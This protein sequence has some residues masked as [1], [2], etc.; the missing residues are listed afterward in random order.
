MMDETI[1]DE[2][3]YEIPETRGKQGERPYAF[4]RPSSGGGSAAYPCKNYGQSRFHAVYY[5]GDFDPNDMRRD[6]TCTV[7]GSTGDG[8]EK[9][10]PFTMGSVANNGGIALNKWDENRQ[11]NPWVIKSR[12][13]GINTPYMRFSDIILMLAEVKAALGDDASAKQY[14][15]MVR[16]RAF[17]ST[18]S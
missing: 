10:I 7:T 9:I 13:A 6:V 2:N 18:S 5:Y 15:S 11:A 17:A 14:L 16:N 4:G 12:Q 1:A 3:V 8:S